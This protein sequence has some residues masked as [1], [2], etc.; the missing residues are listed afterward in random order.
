[1]INKYARIAFLATQAL[2][3]TTHGC[4]TTELD[5]EDGDTD[6]D[7]DVD[8]VTQSASTRPRGPGHIADFEAVP[9]IASK[10]QADID[11]ARQGLRCLSGFMNNSYTAVSNQFYWSCG[12]FREDDY[13]NEYVQLY[14]GVEPT[15]I[16]SFPSITT[17]RLVIAFRGT[18]QGTDWFRNLQSQSAVAPFHTNPLGDGA[19]AAPWAGAGWVGRWTSQATLQRFHSGTPV[20]TLASRIKEHAR[21]A[22]ANNQRLVAYVVGHSLG[23]ATADVAA[24]DIAAWLARQPG[25]AQEVVVAPFNMPRYGA[26]IG[27]AAY[28]AA[29]ANTCTGPTVGRMC[30]T[31]MAMSRTFDPVA[32]IPVNVTGLFPIDQIYWQTSTTDPRRREVPGTRLPY[33]PQFNAPAITWNPLH[34]VSNH[35]SAHWA[36]DINNLSSSHLACMFR[37]P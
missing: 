22:K 20:G 27:R 34:A 2:L 29:L 35:D 33:C 26:A 37:Q 28:N 30:I 24:W 17:R 23:G 21:I 14:S 1:M 15:L 9:R 36:V 32:S 6:T 19:A 7:T 3:I 31:R 18:Y 8:G 5:D 10:S 13:S 12:L 4:A 11:R 25:L 16:P